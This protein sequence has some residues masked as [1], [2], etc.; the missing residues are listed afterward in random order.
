MNLP[1]PG[2]RASGLGRVAMTRSTEVCVCLEQ[3][4][5]A[6]RLGEAR[7]NRAYPISRLNVQ[8]S[9]PHKLVKRG[10]RAYP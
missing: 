4:T 8:S 9:L 10:N 5:E 7:A 2:R 3:L 6:L 1:S